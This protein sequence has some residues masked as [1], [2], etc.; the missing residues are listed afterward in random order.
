MR[1]VPLLV[2]LLLVAAPPLAAQERSAEEQQVVDWLDRFGAEAYVGDLGTYI[3]WFHPDFTAW[4]YSS[5]APL[6]R[7]LFTEM[8]SEFLGAYDSIELMNKPFSVQVIGDVAVM[9]LGYR[10]TMKD[11]GGA[12]VASEGRWTATLKKEGD[13][14]RFLTWTWVETPLSPPTPDS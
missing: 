13:E 8:E 10:L 7:E 1:K 6:G 2:A 5:E 14:W 9:H 11:A 4:D 12:D 3:A